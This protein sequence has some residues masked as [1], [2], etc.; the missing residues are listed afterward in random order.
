[1]ALISGLVRAQAQGELAE[2]KDPRALA[3]FLLV[4][5]QGIRVLGRAGSDPRRV[6]DATDQALALL[7]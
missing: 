1:V 3:H 4:V 6:R 5:L 2:D 7:A